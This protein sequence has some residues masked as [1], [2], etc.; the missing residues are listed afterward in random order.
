MPQGVA[1][2]RPSPRRFRSSLNCLL[3]QKVRSTGDREWLPGRS[4]PIFVEQTGTRQTVVGFRSALAEREDTIWR[5]HRNNPMTREPPNRSAWRRRF[6][7]SLL[8]R[9]GNIGGALAVG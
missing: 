9:S 3:V 7:E 5:A 8:F 1:D 6:Q 2:S 4:R